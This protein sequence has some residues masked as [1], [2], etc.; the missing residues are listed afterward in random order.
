MLY[1]IL[2]RDGKPPGFFT[3]AGIG[4]V[5]GAIGSFVGTPAEISLIRMCA[6]GR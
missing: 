6:D 2:C 3:K 4:M 1:Y 5:A